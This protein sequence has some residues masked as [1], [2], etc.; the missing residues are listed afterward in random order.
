MTKQP[1][2]PNAET[3]EKKV[4]MRTCVA[5]RKTAPRAEM[6][7]FHRAADGVSLDISKSAPGRG[8]WTCSALGCFEKA[9]NKGGLARN[10][11]TGINKEDESRLAMQVGAVLRGSGDAPVLSVESATATKDLGV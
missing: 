10:L 9:L 5:C 3:S 7:R 4:S 2:A 1:S 11:R 6:I 8:A